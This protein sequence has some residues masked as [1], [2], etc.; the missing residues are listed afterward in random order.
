[1]A[2]SLTILTLFLAAPLFFA[3][4]FWYY[5]V[6]QK[7]AHDA[8]RFLATASHLEMATLGEGYSDAPVAA[9]AKQIALAE[10]DEIRPLLDAWTIVV[11][12]DLTQCG[13]TVPQTVRVQVRLRISDKLFSAITDE[14]T[15]GQGINLT[16]DSTMSYAGN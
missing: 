10:T 2:F 14:F 6:A 13:W 7:A 16:A 8:A 5:S 12:C 15:N 9:L 11:Q 3:Q 1:M 4:V